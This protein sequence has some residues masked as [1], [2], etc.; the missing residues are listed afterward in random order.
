MSND[1]T[2]SPPT[3]GQAQGAYGK[4][5]LLNVPDFNGGV[6][7]NGPMSTYLRLGAIESPFHVASKNAPR[8]TG[9]DLA[10]QVTSFID[11]TRVREGCPG[12]VPPAERQAETAILHTKGG[13]RDHTDGNRITTT[14]GD[15]VEVIRGNY[16]MVVM[17]RKDGDLDVAGWDASGGHVSESGVTYDGASVIEYTTEE[18]GGTWSVVEHTRKAHVHTAFHGKVFNYYC[19]ELVETITGSEAPNTLQ[20]NPVVTETTFAASITNHTGSLVCP[21]PAISDS[22]FAVAM[23]NTTYADMMKNMTVVVGEMSDSTAAGAMTSTT[24]AATIESNTIATTMTSTTTAALVEDTTIAAAVVSTTIGNSLSTIV[25][26]ESE[27]IVGNMLEVTTG[28]EESITIGAVLELTLGLMVD[29]C[30]AGRV[31]VDIGPRFEINAT[32]RTE[33]NVTKDEV[34]VTRNGV[35]VDETHTGSVYSRLSMLNV[36]L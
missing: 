19:G 5:F 3:A 17:C 15:K 35:T 24:K 32:N 10:A 36:F 12:Y 20:P 33:V 31:S 8:A 26:N 22:T 21:V 16:R 1:G 23:D 13:W 34:T 25:G 28:A 29:L 11:D 14:R 2:G 4:Y 7:P 9:E 18:Y 6:G 30:I 27:I